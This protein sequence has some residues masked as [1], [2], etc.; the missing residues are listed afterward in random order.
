MMM[1]LLLLLLVLLVIMMHGTSDA[2]P[3]IG[4]PQSSKWYIISMAM[5]CHGSGSTRDDLPKVRLAS[6]LA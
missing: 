2:R 6:E 5:G 1:M 4:L 3:T